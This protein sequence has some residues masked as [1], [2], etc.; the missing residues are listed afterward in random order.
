M[1]KL[2]FA[3]KTERMSGGGSTAVEREMIEIAMTIAVETRKT[4]QIT[5]FSTMHQIEI[6][7]ISTSTLRCTEFIIVDKALPATIFLE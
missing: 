5:L 4:L 2:H 6:V 7:Q 1:K 3:L